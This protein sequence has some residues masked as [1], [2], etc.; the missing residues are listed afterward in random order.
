MSLFKP[1]VVLL[2]HGL[3]ETI[4]D[5]FRFNYSLLWKGIIEGN[6]SSI[7]MAARKLNVEDLFPLL[8]AMVAGRSWQSIKQGKYTRCI[9]KNKSREMKKVFF[10]NN[11]FL[12]K[13]FEIIFFLK[14][15]FRH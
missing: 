1:E 10:S 2:D 12:F 11:F 9:Y 13:I 8:S 15:W 7:R 3:Y 5:E 4:T 14:S 6:L